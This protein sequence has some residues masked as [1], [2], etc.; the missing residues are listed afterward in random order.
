MGKTKRQRRRKQLYASVSRLH[1]AGGGAQVVSEKRDKKTDEWVFSCNKCGTEHRVRATKAWEAWKVAKAAGWIAWKRGNI[2]LHFCSWIHR[3]SYEGDLKDKN[4]KT[5]ATTKEHV[6][7]YFAI[8][9]GE[10]VKG[11][12]FD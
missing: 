8:E 6:A 5:A 9:R 3:G 4:A 10:L 1:P 2:W 11:V 12:D 7:G